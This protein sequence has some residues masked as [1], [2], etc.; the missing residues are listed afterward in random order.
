MASFPTSVKTFAARSNGQTIDAAHVG[1]L[2]DEVN[3]IE[4]GFLNGTARL[5]SSHSTVV[6]LSVAGGST[7][8]TLRVG[9]TASFASSVTFEG[10][11]TVS[12]ALIATVVNPPDA[13]R[14]ALNAKVDIT[15]N[16]TLAISW[17]TA[18]FATNSS[19]HSTTTNPERMTPQS[20]GIYAIQ[21]TIAGNNNSGSSASLEVA[22]EDSSATVI[23]V[24]RGNIAGGSGPSGFPSA[25]AFALKRFDS[26]TGSTQWVRAVVKQLDAGSTQS[27][28]S[29]R[30]CCHFWK[31]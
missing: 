14:L 25:S 28:D 31:L 21:V 11:V 3:A 18:H 1:D 26:I 17:S 12:G 4:D 13:V 16:T 27:L 2:Q 9:S 6:A 22:I 5:N 19:I 15:H 7:L 20:T 29:T 10:N 30:T 23:G 24:G 8:A